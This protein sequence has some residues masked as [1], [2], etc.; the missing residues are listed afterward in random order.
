[1]LA[2]EPI[3]L[4]RSLLL[5]RLFQTKLLFLEVQQFFSRFLQLSREQ[6]VSN[7]R[8]VHQFEWESRISSF[9]RFSPKEI[10]QL[11]VIVGY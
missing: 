3:D 5:S 6:L 10:P 2:L 9:I 8:I 11:A 4:A 7:Y 1:M